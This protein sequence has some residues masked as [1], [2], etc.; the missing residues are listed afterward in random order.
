MKN[1]QQIIV[2][3]VADLK[4]RNRGISFDPWPP[5]TG[6]L[7]SVWMA[8]Y[9]HEAETSIPRVFREYSFV[10]CDRGLKKNKKEILV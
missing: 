9:I 1:T 6:I 7:K 3:L 5:L 2:T 4:K 8:M 10:T